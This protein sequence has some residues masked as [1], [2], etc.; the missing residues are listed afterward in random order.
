M[1]F[2]KGKNVLIT[3]HTGFKGSW[4][5]VMLLEL[6]ANVTGYSLEHKTERDNFALANLRDKV[7]H[8]IGDIRDTELLASTFAQRKP[9]IVFHLAAQ[10]LVRYAYEYPWETY[11][12]NVMGTLSVL[13]NVKMASYVRELIIV[14]TDKCYENKEQIWGYRETDRLG[15]YDMYSSSKACAELLVASYRN[16]FLNVDKYETHKK[17]VS[18]VRAGNVIGGGD[19]SDGRLIPDC[20]RALEAGREIRLRCPNSVRPWQHV[21]EPLSGYLLLAE[22][23]REN[24]REYSGAWNFGP[25]ADSMKTVCEA[26]QLVVKNYGA[27]S[28]KDISDKNAP[29]E[30]ALLFLDAAKARVKL[31]YKTR[32]TLEEAI[33][34]TLDWYKGYRENDVYNICRNQIAKYNS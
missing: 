9:E 32:L 23:M 20:I 16:S 17:S 8:V 28:I 33:E 31:G 30:A 11:D 21:L 10:P 14:T 34:L 12:V 19:W 25:N 5:T 15:G 26:A 13:E 3:G 18:T 27:G 24:P 4:L 2:F 7:Y 1:S 6:G 22:K 29:H